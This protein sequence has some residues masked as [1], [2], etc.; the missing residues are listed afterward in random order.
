M[1]RRWEA[2]HRAAI[3]N[4]ESEIRHVVAPSLLNYS[5]LDASA[6]TY[7]I[8]GEL[9][10]PLDDRRLSATDKSSGVHPLLCH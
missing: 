5:V 6:V 8:G 3:G 7:Q 1:G 2:F 9:A 10:I 4:R